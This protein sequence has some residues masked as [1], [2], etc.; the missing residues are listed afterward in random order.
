MSL[1][2]SVPGEGQSLSP[3]LRTERTRHATVT[4]GSSLWLERQVTSGSVGVA[5]MVAKDKSCRVGRI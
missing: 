3:K 1:R 4:K 2:E 5:G